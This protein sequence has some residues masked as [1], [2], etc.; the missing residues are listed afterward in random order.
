MN[1]FR[2]L[3]AGPK[4]LLFIFL[5]TLSC[6]AA[7]GQ[8]LWP[9]P[10]PTPLFPPL[11]GLVYPQA[12]PD[13]KTP[14]STTIGEMRLALTYFNG[15]LDLYKFVETQIIPISEQVVKKYNQLVFNY[16]LV[17]VGSGILLIAS[18]G[19]VVFLAVR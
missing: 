4:A 15:Y 5:F 10:I 3:P 6:L 13:D 16:K 1:K 7:N 14:K 19:L 17:L 8:S 2:S 9:S 11:P 12:Q 18:T